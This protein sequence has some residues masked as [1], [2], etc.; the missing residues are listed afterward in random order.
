M[1][2]L[3]YWLYV[4]QLCSL[5]ALFPGPLIP[6]P[7]KLRLGIIRVCYMP[8]ALAFSTGMIPCILATFFA[9]VSSTAT[10]Q[11]MFC[12]FLN[13]TYALL[14]CLPALLTCHVNV[15]VPYNN[16]SCFV[17]IG[18]VSLHLTHSKANFHALPHA[19]KS[20][21]EQSAKQKQ[22]RIEQLR[23]RKVHE[24]SAPGLVPLNHSP[25]QELLKSSKRGKNRS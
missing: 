6:R 18:V 12:S 5:V 24:Q 19:H 23:K 16:W 13:D 14:T 20:A 22:K 8:L 3:Q 21:A 25:P 15:G 2:V 17:M 10:A 4:Q 1:L 7:L 11:H 9:A